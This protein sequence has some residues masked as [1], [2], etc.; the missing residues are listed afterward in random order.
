MSVRDMDEW[1]KFYKGFTMI[2]PSK[3]ARDM[4]GFIPDGSKIL[5][6][7]CGNGRDS[8]FLGKKYDVLGIDF[9][10]EPRETDNVKF[11]RAPID[12]IYN[13][14]PDDF[15]VVYSRFFFSAVENY[16]IEDVLDWNTGMV[17]S[18]SR[19]EG[20]IPKIYPDHDR[21]FMDSMWFLETLL[22]K[23]YEVIYHERGCNMAMYK[24]EDPIVVR[25]VS[26]KIR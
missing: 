22:D 4:L 11:L 13:L 1:E 23:N 24:D 12:E 7:G 2:E 26:R 8:Y 3:F 14:D 20:D 21:N 15:D 9:A 16:V 5:D 6:I 10:I 18:E 19:G 25:N 17:L